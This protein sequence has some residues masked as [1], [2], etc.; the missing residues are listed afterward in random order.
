MFPTDVDIPNYGLV[1]AGGS[2]EEES[3]KGAGDDCIPERECPDCNGTG[4][5]DLTVQAPRKV[6]CERCGGDGTLEPVEEAGN[7]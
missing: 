6:E 5:I 1:D 7:G 2:D 3:S 4:E